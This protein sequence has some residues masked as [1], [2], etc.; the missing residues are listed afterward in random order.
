MIY[1]G[2]GHFGN[3]WQRERPYA[4]DAKCIEVYHWR[5]ALVRDAADEPCIDETR[6]AEHLAASLADPAASAAILQRMQRYRDS[7]GVYA[8]GGCIDSTREQIKWVC[9][10]TGD[11]VLPVQ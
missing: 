10:G 8:D 2:G 9:E 1:L 4:L 11:L 5:H 3:F 7:R 6:V